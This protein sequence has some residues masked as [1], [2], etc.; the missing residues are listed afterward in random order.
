MKSH[1]FPLCEKAGLVINHKCT[2][3]CN[4]KHDYIIASQVEAFFSKAPI[5]YRYEINGA[6]YS[7]WDHD[8][9]PG[10]THTARLVM[11]ELIKKKSREENLAEI[12]QSFYN[13]A[14]SSVL[15]SD[16]LIKQASAILKEKK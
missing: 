6:E 7:S 9:D 1:D 4:H 2:C 11:I 16:P 10:N 14:S 3:G 15:P 13:C 5:V 12:L 8:K